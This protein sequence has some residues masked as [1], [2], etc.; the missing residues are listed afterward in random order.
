MSNIMQAGN[1][2]ET[3]YGTGPYLI[4]EVIGPC[5]CSDMSE[6]INGAADCSSAHFHAT[7]KGLAG[8]Q[9]NDVFYLNGY[10]QD[11]RSVW[12]NDFITVVKYADQM[13]FLF[14]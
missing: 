6:L 7:C 12:S 5:T 9:K 4:T 8:H 1:V 13:S 3:S 14:Q 11:G 10:T 2:V